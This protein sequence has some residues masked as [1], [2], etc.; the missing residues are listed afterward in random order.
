MFI[1]D[2]EDTIKSINRQF[3]KVEKK[4]LLRLLKEKQH[5]YDCFFFSSNSVG[6][7]IV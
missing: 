2:C 3:A 7:V 6:L 1:K 5:I 4:L